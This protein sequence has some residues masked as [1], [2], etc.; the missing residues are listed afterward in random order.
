M[1]KTC[2]FQLTLL[3]ESELVAASKLLRGVVKLVRSGENVPS[4]QLAAALDAAATALW[5][6]CEGNP[7]VVVSNDILKKEAA[8]AP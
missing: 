5:H 8:D 2:K 7:I 4:E 3:F 6:A 1:G